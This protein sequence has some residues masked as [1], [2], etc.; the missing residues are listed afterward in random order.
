MSVYAVQSTETPTVGDLWVVA[1]SVRDLDGC[2]TDAA[3]PVVTVTLPNGSTATP[4]VERL[5]VGT[6]RASYAPAASGRYVVTVAA[7]GYGSKALAFYASVTTATAGLPTLAQVKVY[8]K[9]DESD[10]SQDTDITD[11][12]TAEAGAQRAVC[13]TSAVYPDDL[14]Q[15]FKRRVARNLALR[16]LPI[17][18]LRGDAQAGPLVPP[19]NDPEVRRLERPYRKVVLA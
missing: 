13:R 8:L 5:D 12:M 19:G 2:L 16:G 7:S 10:T 9:I 18:V 17:M 11:A 15:A 14:A 1:A 4:T 3:T 6:H